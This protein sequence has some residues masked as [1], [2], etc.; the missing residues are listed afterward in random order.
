MYIIKVGIKKSL[1]CLKDYQ[2]VWPI[3]MQLVVKFYQPS[4]FL[5]HMSYKVHNQIRNLCSNQ[6][7]CWYQ[8]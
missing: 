5:Y 6:R 1:T 3:A 4:Y 2:I 8:L 7:L